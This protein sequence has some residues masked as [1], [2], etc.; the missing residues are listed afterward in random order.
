[1]T[2]TQIFP[3]PKKVFYAKDFGI[4]NLENPEKTAQNVKDK[5]N[6]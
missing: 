5:G 3:K 2:E 6:A 1:M 4:I